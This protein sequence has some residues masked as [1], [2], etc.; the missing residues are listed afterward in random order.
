MADANAAAV[1]Q[2]AKNKLK[3]ETIEGMEALNDCSLRET[4]S[5]RAAT[6]YDIVINM[7]QKAKMLKNYWKNAVDFTG[8]LEGTKNRSERDSL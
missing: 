3:E 7:E 8:G 2:A 4:S 1:V 6:C 5:A